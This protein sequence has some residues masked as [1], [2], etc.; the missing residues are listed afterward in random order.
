MFFECE[1][2]LQ[3]EIRF[4]DLVLDWL[5]RAVEEPPVEALPDG[6][7]LAL[8]DATLDPVDQEA[9]SLLLAGHR[10]GLRSRVPKVKVWTVPG[11]TRFGH[12]E[13]PTRISLDRPDHRVA[14]VRIGCMDGDALPWP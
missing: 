10:S 8:C 9:L 7:L 3:I 6:E 1:P 4:E 13:A 12:L 14:T 2:L 11:H 5:R